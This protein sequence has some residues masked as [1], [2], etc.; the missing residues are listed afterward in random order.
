MVAQ[1]PALPKAESGGIRKSRRATAG[2]ATDDCFTCTKRHVKCDRR[3]PYCSLCLEIGDKCSGYKTQLTWGVGVASRG[4]HRGL[5]LPVAEASPVSK[6]PKKAPAKSQPGATTTAAVRSIP[7]H[8]S[9]MP[10]RTHTAPVDVPTVS[11]AASAPMTPYGLSE[12]DYISVSHAQQPPQMSHGGWAN[13]QYSPEAIVYQVDGPHKY[14]HSPLAL[15]TDNPAS[16]VDSVGSVV[17]YISPISHQSFL[18]EMHFIPRPPILYDGYAAHSANTS[19]THQTSPVPS[20]PPS[21][22]VVNHTRAPASRPSLVYAPSESSSHLN[23]HIDTFESHLRH[24][25]M[26]ECA[27]LSEH[28]PEPVP[29]F[30]C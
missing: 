9:E 4:K 3:R 7:N 1:H 14:K 29:A 16:V 18:R 26:R 23:S 30:T 27:N 21:A 15:V 5:S 12:N 11:H 24:K 2:G 10:R 22:I 20:C 28:Q 13:L 19:A 6:D 17:D 8:D 25:V